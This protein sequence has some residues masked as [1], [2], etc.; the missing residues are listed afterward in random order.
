MVSE[1]SFYLEHFPAVRLEGALGAGRGLGAGLP[2]AGAA[3]V[4]G[5]DALVGWHGPW[6]GLEPGVRTRS[7]CGSGS[8]GGE[9]KPETVGPVGQVSAK[10]G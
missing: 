7:A 1:T 6:R 9:M 4:L 5:K 3:W 10:A 8:L 2:G